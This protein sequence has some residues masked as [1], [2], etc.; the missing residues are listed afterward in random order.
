MPVRVRSSG[1]S[2]QKGMPEFES[3][4]LQAV[5]Q[6]VAFIRH[7]GGALRRSVG[8]RLY[9]DLPSWLYG[10][11]RCARAA[12]A[13]LLPRAGADRAWHALDG[14]HHQRRGV[15]LYIAT[16]RADLFSA[17]E[18]SRPPRHRGLFRQEPQGPETRRLRPEGRQDLRLHQPYDPLRG[19][20]AKHA[21]P[22]VQN[23]QVL[24]SLL[25]GAPLVVA[26]L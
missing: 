23:L 4:R 20:R 13:W 7:R 17:A 25:V 26:P 1:L 24:T 19:R 6:K 12:S 3:A 18:R 5:C 8:L 21:R 15:L 16:R 22:D 11:R 14:R 9:A 2:T 10:P